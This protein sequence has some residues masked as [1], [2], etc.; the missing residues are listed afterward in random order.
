MNVEV[1]RSKKR[2]KTV[3][4]RRVGGVIRVSIPATM[5]KA[6]EERWVGEMVRRIE[7]KVVAGEVDLTARAEALADRFGLP[8]PSSI[9]WV[10]NQEARWGSC[11]PV[12]RTVRISSRVAGYPAWVV[13]YVVVHELAHLVVP[14]H[15]PDFWRVVNRYP[16]TERA[17][18]FLEAASLLLNGD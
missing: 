10:D 15:G 9:R 17:R 16:K 1:V 13:D 5:T 4:A 8:R 2:R 3:S 6:E 7:R 14:G 11:T 12:D 18:G